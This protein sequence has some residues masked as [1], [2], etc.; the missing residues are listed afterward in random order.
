MASTTVKTECAPEA[1]GPYS[2]GVI[3]ESSRL[4][5]T[6]MQIP[7]DPAMGCLVEDNI[8]AQTNRVIE[9]IKAVLEAAGSGL[10]RVI[11]TTVYL[12]EMD[13]FSVMNRIYGKYFGENPPARSAVEVAR[14]PK[15]ARIGIECVAFV[16]S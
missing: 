15:D 16:S 5:F 10:D 9:N 13:D 7:L 8:E 1:I 12:K 11:K 4:V 14:L 6:A 2:Q 3:V